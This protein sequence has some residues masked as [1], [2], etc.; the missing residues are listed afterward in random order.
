MS[1]GPI[2]PQALGFQSSA[3]GPTPG[4]P[5]LP[6]APIAGPM[7]TA[8]AGPEGGAQA[9]LG[10]ESTAGKS[11]GGIGRIIKNVVGFG[12]LGA[13][14]G[15]LAQLTPLP[16]VAGAGIAA[17]AAGGALGAVLGLVRS[18]K[19]GADSVAAAGQP[20]GPELPVAPTAPPPKMSKAPEVAA[21]PPPAAPAKRATSAASIKVRRGDTLSAIAAQHGVSWRQLYAANREAIGSNPDLIHPG[22]ELTLPK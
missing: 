20:V 4:A 22:M 10:A 3:A 6:G 9:M 8:I 11:S 19:G 21:T 18:R 13:G 17:V 2:S 15:F 1:I 14:L 16:I 7:P 5:G 12:G